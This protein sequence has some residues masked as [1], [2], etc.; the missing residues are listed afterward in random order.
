MKLP[1]SSALAGPYSLNQWINWQVETRD[2]KPTKVPY[3]PGSLRRASVTDP[4][5]WR[6]LEAADADGR[7][8]G[9]VFTADDPYLVIDLDHCI[10]N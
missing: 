7:D 8:I 9:F 1:L 4:S 6:S 3:I 10:K 2:G 5:T